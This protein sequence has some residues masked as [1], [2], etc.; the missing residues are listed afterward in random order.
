MQLESI[1]KELLARMKDAGDSMQKM[2]DTDNFD[3]EPSYD[4]EEGRSDAYGCAAEMIRQFIE[5]KKKEAER[6]EIVCSC[7]SD[8]FDY[9]CGP[10]G[11]IYDVDD[12]THTEGNTCIC[13][14]CGKTYTWT[15]NYKLT[16]EDFEEECE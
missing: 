5:Q 13:N 3:A 9:D 7:G 16:S 15:R 1:M 11:G 6:K 8:D 10:D 4:Y 14:D 12:T 2:I